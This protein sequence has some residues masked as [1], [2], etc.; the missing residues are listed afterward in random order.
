MPPVLGRRHVLVERS[1]A[2]GQTIFRA[3]GQQTT[4]S[5]W[6]APRNREARSG[7][8]RSTAVAVARPRSARLRRVA[9]SP[10]SSVV[11]EHSHPWIK[12]SS[13][14]AWPSL[15]GQHGA[16]GVIAPRPRL[17]PA[18]NDNSPTR[19]STM[20]AL[21]FVQPRVEEL[22]ARVGPVR[23]RRNRDDSAALFL[24]HRF[25]PTA[26]QLQP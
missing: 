9:Q 3:P 12:N 17:R 26:A 4:A 13:W 18:G 21:G 19:A 15:G 16:A 1:Y 6:P 10:P 11:Q 2:L 23:L 14:T 24:D 25:D 20:L 5:G 7:R 8:A 22:A